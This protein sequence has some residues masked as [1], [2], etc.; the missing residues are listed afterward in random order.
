[1]Q[2][3]LN[4]L[5][6][7]SRPLSM[8]FVFSSFFCLH[9]KSCNLSLGNRFPLLVEC[10]LLLQEDL[11]LV[12]EAENPRRGLVHEGQLMV[13]PSVLLQYLDHRPVTV[14]ILQ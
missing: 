12:Y 10:I 3:I 11:L 9:E 6:V 5:T 7:S 1:M 2:H 4:V 14:L 8:F 13:R